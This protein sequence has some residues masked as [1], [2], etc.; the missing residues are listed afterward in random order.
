MAI[1]VNGYTLPDPDIGIKIG[2]STTVNSVRNANNVLVGEK[3]GRDLYKIDGLKWTFLEASEWARI[4]Q[5]TSPFYV[6]VTFN[7][8]VTDTK[9][10]I[11]MYVNEQE[12]EPVQDGNGNVVRYKNCKFELIDVGVI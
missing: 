10:T 11:K 5:A 8:P 6:D 7:D 2:L 9:K 1:I 4:L 12:G 3:V